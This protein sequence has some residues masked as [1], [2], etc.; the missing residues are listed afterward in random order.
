M[1]EGEGLQLCALCYLRD[2]DSAAPY[3]SHGNTRGMSNF[4]GF[5]DS[6]C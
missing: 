2:H 1:K 5:D 3:M 6:P 4:E